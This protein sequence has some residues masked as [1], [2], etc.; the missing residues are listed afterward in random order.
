MLRDTLGQTYRKVL[1]LHVFL[2]A[3]TTMAALLVAGGLAAMSAL[4]GGATVLFGSA[5]Y[6]LVARESKVTAVSAGRVL[7]RHLFAEVA[8]MLVMLGLLLVSLASGLFVA[9]WLVAAAGVAL[10]GHWLAL[11]IIR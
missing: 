5:T 9:G 6:A 3:I 11:L 10:L 4:I 8:K 7:G 1:L 2:M